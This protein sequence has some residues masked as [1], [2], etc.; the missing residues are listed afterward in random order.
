MN[1]SILARFFS[2]VIV[3]LFCLV[4]IF[5]DTTFTAVLNGAQEIPPNV[6]AAK[7]EGSVILNAA[8][9]QITVTLNFSSLTDAPIAAHL[10]KGER[11][12]AGA[13]EIELPNFGFSQTF[14][15]TPDQV[16]G[17]K[18]GLWYFDVHSTAFPD[19]EVRGQ[20]EA[21]CSPPLGGMI[22]NF[23]SGVCASGAFLTSGVANGKI[24]FY[25]SPAENYEIFTMNA[26]GSNQTNVSNRAA[27]DYYPAWSPDGSKIAFT[28]RGFTDDI[29]VMN[30]DGTNQTKLTTDNAAYESL[31]NWSPDGSKITFYKDR[32]V[33]DVPGD[34]WIM[35]SD[36]SHQIRLT[37]NA[38]NGFA[39]KFSPDG[40]Q[41]VFGSNRDGN[42]EIYVMNADGSNQTRLT[43]NLASDDYPSFSPDGS[44]IAFHRITR[45]KTEIFVMNADGSNQIQLTDNS[46]PDVY[47]AWSPDGSKISFT[48]WTST[49]GYVIYTMNA[50]GSNQIGLTVNSF[51]S[52]YSAWQ[53][54]GFAPASQV[55]VTPARNLKI[56]FSEIS[57]AGY[58]IATPLSNDQVPVLPAGYVLRS[59]FAYDIR[60]SANYSGGVDVQ[61]TV[62]DVFDQKTCSALRVLHFVDGNWDETGNQAPVFDSGVCTLRQN[63]VSLSPFV[64]AEQTP[65]TQGR[66]LSGKIIYGTSST[67][68]FVSGV[69]LTAAAGAAN[70]T[71][72]SDSTG[73]Y[74]IG[75]LNSANG[76]IVTPSKEGD[77]NEVTAFDATL[78]LRCVAAGAS[79]ALTPNQK[80]AANTDDN[81]TITSFDAT[82][83]LR[84]VAAN[85]ANS[86][87]GETGKWKFAPASRGYG[88]LLNSAS[89]ENFTA[90]LIG[91]VDGNW[92]P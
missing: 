25:R 20:L 13:V 78:V 33:P 53:R 73:D 79:C 69:L 81:G 82:Q 91:E 18:A 57:Q 50:D 62:P 7:G 4:S 54:I 38:V 45:D 92:T 90:I 49:R 14:P 27:E 42:D 85:G 19:G 26:D 8:E 34:V 32:G 64:V 89:G 31:P 71:A 41:I 48:R 28:S 87:T 3:N 61:F 59:G 77:I 55:F 35:D 40:S 24:A 60:T 44:K 2:I 66:V 10:H 56:T 63:A 30:A 39:P 68:K 74:L 5:A 22:G 80:L 72:D 29:Y 9:T 84:F 11:G 1:A 70:Q 6:S 83:I 46:I 88:S 86:A 67:A 43:N 21:L 51:H 15:V 37:D 36:G 52:E 47:P 16:A 76:Y 23:D 17:L 75:S 12:T 65:E 58:T